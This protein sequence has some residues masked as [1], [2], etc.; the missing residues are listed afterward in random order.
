M[1]TMC[2]LCNLHVHTCSSMLS[3]KTSSLL[4]RTSFRLSNL[5]NCLQ[6]L[7]A[8][9]YISKSCKHDIYVYSTALIFVKLCAQTQNYVLRAT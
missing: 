3:R 5:S 1:K 7:R 6:G 2:Y 9:E 4:I 8:Q